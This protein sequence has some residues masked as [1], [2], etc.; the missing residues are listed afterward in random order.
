MAA[1]DSL[2]L[3]DLREGETDDPTA[4]TEEGLSYVPPI[5]PPVRTDADQDDRLVIA[6]GIAVS[7]ESEPYDDDHRSTDLDAESE[8]NGRIR[9]ALR[10]DAATSSLADQL[11]DRDTRIDVAVIRG[12]V[13]GR[14]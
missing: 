5:D 4:A 11:I 1:L 12:A 3:E 14:G 8:M 2:D 10:A 7:A 6:A 9:E 13:R